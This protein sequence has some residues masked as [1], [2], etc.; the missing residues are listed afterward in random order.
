MDKGHDKHN[1]NVLLLSLLEGELDSEA[2]LWL[3]TQITENPDVARYYAEFIALYTGLK[4]A[5]L[6][7]T[8]AVDKAHSE[9]HLASEHTTHTPLAVSGSTDRTHEIEAFARQQLEAYLQ[10]QNNNKSMTTSRTVDLFE[11]I[12]NAGRLLSGTTQLLF[13][14]V[15]V[16]VLC[17]IAGLLILTAVWGVRS[18]RIVATLVDTANA[19]WEKAPSQVELRRGSRVLRQGFAKIRFLSGAEVL[20]QAPCAFKLDTGNRMTL[21]SGALC[22]EVPKGAKGFS[23]DTPLS[24]VVDYGTEFGILV[25]GDL[26]AEVH[27]F[28]GEIGIGSPQARDRSSLRSIDAGKAALVHHFGGIDVRPLSERS[29]VFQRS[30]ANHASLGIPGLRIDLADIVGGGNGFGTGDMHGSINPLTGIPNDTDG[31]KGSPQRPPI[32]RQ[33]VKGGYYTRGLGQFQPVPQL[34]YV[35]GVF[36]PDPN[37][38]CIISS[39]GHVFNNCSHLSGRF[40]FSVMNVAGPLPGHFFEE[41]C[42]SYT[43]FL[44]HANLGITFDLMQIRQTMPGIDIR[45]FHTQAGIPTVPFPEYSEADIW[46]LV[47]GELRFVR[48][49]IRAT[50]MSDI[51]IPIKAQER[52]L[53]LIATD[54]QLPA[55]DDVEEAHWDH[56]F[57][58][59][60]VLELESTREKN[61]I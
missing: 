54:G 8:S 48:K 22:A 2:F 40:I 17:G 13:K 14:T 56:C 50:E 51:R 33:D 58:V 31:Q 36:V 1:L 25:G 41:L 55:P 32:L 43:G 38:P 42:A 19:E 57:F 34:P 18:H 47:D 52:F 61:G 27:V 46:V 7:S 29:K 11:L 21:T 12:H 49:G 60:P 10:D 26:Q 23:V 45:A 6:F 24:R 59:K 15:K 4:Q 37:V 44:L 20:L 9:V 30:L 16:A 39:T 53:T 3:D 5:E 28:N 35:D